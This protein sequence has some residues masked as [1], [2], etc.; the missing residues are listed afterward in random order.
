MLTSDHRLTYH[1]LI[2]IS[3]FLL[4]CGDLPSYRLKSRTA[5]LV[6]PRPRHLCSLPTTDTTAPYPSVQYDRPSSTPL[7]NFL[8]SCSPNPILLLYKLLRAASPD[9]ATAESK[10]VVKPNDAPFCLWHGGP[11]VAALALGSM[12]FQTWHFP[13]TQTP[14]PIPICFRPRR[15]TVFT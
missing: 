8:T 10:S 14:S 3:S 9:P 6:P 7:L 15:L 13:A 4:A 2:P 12:G 1:L 5:V 11:A